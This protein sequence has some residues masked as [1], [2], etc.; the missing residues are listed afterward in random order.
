MR[1]LSP[2]QEAI[3]NNSATQCGF[4]T[5]GLVMSLT[6]HSV[7]GEQSTN[8]AAIAAVSGNICRCTGYKSI[9]KAAK[10]ISDLL[11]D[12]SI[13]NPIQWLISK[14]FLPEYFL[15]IPGR[16]AEI[17]KCRSRLQS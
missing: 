3:V 7:S 5:P 8:Q 4:C 1:H 9:E 12:R 2:V 14:H 11:K 15:T 13:E 17:G 6:A 10:D 16:L